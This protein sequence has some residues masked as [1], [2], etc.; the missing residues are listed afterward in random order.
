[1]NRRLLKTSRKAAVWALLLAI[2]LFVTPI[3]VAQPRGK[4]I[5]G[6]VVDDA[7]KPLVGATVVVE[8]KNANAITD[9]HGHYQITASRG[10]M[11]VFNFLG[12]HPQ[13]IAVG[14]QT[15]IDV[16]MLTDAVGVDEVVVVGYGVQ[17]RRD[18]TTSIS[19]VTP[20]KLQDM[21]LFDINQAMSGQ[22]AGVNVISASGSPGGGADIQIRGLSTLSADTSP[23]YVVDGVVLQ[24]GSDL[25]S[26][27]F[28]FINPADVASIEI[29]KDAAAAAIYGS[30]ASNGVVLITTKSGETG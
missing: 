19:S 25:E 11:L 1:M 17:N 28:S 9:I 13:K 8:G 10:D 27:P 5:S 7:K 29:L 23:L 18:V 16:Q 14:S 4:T 12:M 6:T 22:A 15:V 21:P 24:L 3:T 26:G 30:R 20:D 2:G